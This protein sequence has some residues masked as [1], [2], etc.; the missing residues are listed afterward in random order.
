MGAMGRLGL[1]GVAMAVVGGCASSGGVRRDL[2]RLQSQVGLI[3]ERVGQLERGGFAGLPSIPS[4]EI[5]SQPWSAEPIPAMSS[6]SASPS[7]TPSLKP[8]NREIQEALKGAGFYQ[9]KVDGK[10]GPLTKEAVREFQRVHGLTDDGVVGKKTWEKL[11]AYAELSS[12][13]GGTSSAS[14][15]AK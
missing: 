11:R 13:S 3:D 8:S 12:S 6:A 14:D 5:A 7:K 1:L 9:G 15:L 4:P 10:M 2:A